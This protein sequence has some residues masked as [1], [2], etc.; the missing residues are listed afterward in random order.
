MAYPQ[1]IFGWCAF[2]PT[3]S[4]W[5]SDLEAGESYSGGTDAD[6]PHQSSPG[7]D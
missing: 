2:E 6:M 5:A 1:R 7:E 3:Q 4:R